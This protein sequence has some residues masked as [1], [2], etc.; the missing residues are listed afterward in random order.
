MIKAESGKGKEPW[1]ARLKKDKGEGI[2]PLFVILFAPPRV[3]CHLQINCGGILA[4]WPVSDKG[5]F[6]REDHDSGASCLRLVWHFEPSQLCS[7]HRYLTVFSGLYLPSKQAGYGP[8]TRDLVF[9][10]SGLP[11]VPEDAPR[12]TQVYHGLSTW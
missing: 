12:R 1:P 11:F 10:L 8:E 7:L 3:N 4:I 2:N 9:S 5:I 6:R